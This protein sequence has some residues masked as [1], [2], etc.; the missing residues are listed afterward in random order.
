MKAEIASVN[1]AR[2]PALQREAHRLRHRDPVGAGGEHAA[3]FHAHAKAE[4]ADRAGVGRVAVVVEVEHARQQHAGL[5][6]E[7]MAVPAAADVEKVFDA[8]GFGGG[9]VERAH[10]GRARAAVDHFVVG[11]HHDLVG[12]GET[13][14]ADG[15]EFA[16]GAAHDTV[17]NH[18]EIGRRAARRRRAARC[19][20]N[21]RARE[22][23]R[24]RSNPCGLS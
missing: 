10:L 3:D 6:R 1:A 8:P 4:R 7:D 15:V 14:D 21:S 13:V 2:E 17:V 5:H 9:A 20:A 12:R 22:F 16:L 11:H 19:A 18:D 24:P 23:F